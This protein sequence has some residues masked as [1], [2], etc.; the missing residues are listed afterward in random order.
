MMNET[1]L[2]Q[3]LKDIEKVHG[4]K[5]LLPIEIEYMNGKINFTAYLNR[6]YQ[7]FSLSTFLFNSNG[8]Q[9]NISEIYD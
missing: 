4:T 5:V 6:C 3:H 9:I 2:K 8:N 7:E 1:E